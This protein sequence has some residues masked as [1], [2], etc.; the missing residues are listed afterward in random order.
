MFC[1]GCEAGGNQVVCVAEQSR[2]ARSLARQWAHVPSHGRYHLQR[3][4]GVSP[5][6]IGGEKSQR[7]WSS[8]FEAVQYDKPFLYLQRF[9]TQSTSIATYA[10]LIP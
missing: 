9:D 10:Y 1:L 6:D 8:Q 3:F 2:I 5:Y 7:H 4:G